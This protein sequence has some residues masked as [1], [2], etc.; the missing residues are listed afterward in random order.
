VYKVDLH[1]LHQTTIPIPDPAFA[2]SIT[3]DPGSGTIWVAN[4]GCPR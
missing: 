2:G 1:T 4:C 3:A